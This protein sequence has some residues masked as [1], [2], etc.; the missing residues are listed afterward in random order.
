VNLKQAAQY[1]GVHYQTAYKLVRS[2]RL[3]AVCV[4]AR[5]EISEAAIER[6]LAERRAMRRSPLRAEPRPP[7]DLEDAYAAAR[8]VLDAAA[9]SARTVAELVAEALSTTIGD[10]AVVR[11][12]SRDGSTFLPAIVRHADPRRRATVAASIGDV[13]LDVGASNVLG[14]VARGE[15]VLKALVPQDCIRT[16]IDPEVIQYYDEAGFHSMIVAPAKS[17]GEVVGLVSISRDNPGRPYTR[18]DVATVEHAAALVGSGIARARIGSES[19]AR[20]RSLVGAVAGVIEGGESTLSVHSVLG[21]GSVAELV[22]DAAGRIVAC[23]DAAVTL[24]GS[25]AADIVGRR[26]SDLAQHEDRDRQRANLDRLL[27][28]ELDFLDTRLAVVG[29]LHSNQQVAMRFAV[30]RD[31]RAHPRAIVVTAHGLPAA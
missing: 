1:L 14:A 31:A 3:A 26:L 18:D 20:V 9:V 4:G 6:Y 25:G 15:T 7:A 17:G 16:N 8:A 21:D 13:Q 19:R 11:E 22:C 28:G 10:L 5:Y 23:N 29:N 27:R 30:V 2:G 24:L 12:L